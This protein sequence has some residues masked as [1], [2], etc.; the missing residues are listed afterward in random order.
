MTK[1]FWYFFLHIVTRLIR[2]LSEKILITRNDERMQQRLFYP[3]IN[4]R[5]ESRFRSSPRLSPSLANRQFQFLSENSIQSCQTSGISKTEQKRRCLSFTWSAGNGRRDDGATPERDTVRIE[6]ITEV[7]CPYGMNRFQPRLERYGSDRRRRGE[8]N[9]H[10][11]LLLLRGKLNK[12][13]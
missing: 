2:S 8:R 7:Y 1:A 3:S 11:W 13:S 10:C 9:R 4:Q 6:R 5:S 12:K